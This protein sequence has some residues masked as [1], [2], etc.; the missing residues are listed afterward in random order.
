MNFRSF[1]VKIHSKKRVKIVTL[2][3]E[4]KSDCISFSWSEI[5]L[6]EI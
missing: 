1:E 3:Q 6:Q 5:S 4:V 2:F